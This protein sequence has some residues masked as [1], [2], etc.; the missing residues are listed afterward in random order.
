MASNNQTPVQ[1][2]TIEELN[3]HLTNLGRR[4][5]TNKR[6]MWM[7]MVAILV[8]A[9]LTFAWLYLIRIPNNNKANEAYNKVE[10]NALGN[11]STAA[12][13]YK[14]VADEYGNYDAGKLAALSAAQNL[15]TLGK[16]QEA[17]KYLEKFSCSDKVLDANAKILLG[18]CF[19]NLKKYDDALSAFKKAESKAKG[20]PQIAPR[21]LLKEAVVYDELKKYSDALSCY[22]TI[23]K[24]YPEF[25][26]GNG[27]SIDS[28]IE[29]EKARL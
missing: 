2:D 29:R 22:E 3:T 10:L 15:Y 6:A 14:K 13:Q 11:D 5:E 23:K 18:D 24:D 26:L 12:A 21:A 1:P 4:I 19:V 16:Y 7:A 27:L 9:C 28:Y 8:V 25:Q 20:N 17:A